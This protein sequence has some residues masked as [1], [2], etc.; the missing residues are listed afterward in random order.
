MSDI[1]I[2]EATA[3]DA[4]KLLEYIEKIASDTEFLT[5][6]PGEF[7]LT[8]DQERDT[9]DSYSLRDNALYLVAEI[10]GTIVG[11]LNFSGGS[12]LRTAHTGEFG[13]SVLKAYWG[14]HIGKVLLKTLIEWAHQFHIIRKIN[15]RVREDNDRAIRLYTSLG[16][17]Q[18]GIIKRDLFI[19]GRFYSS[20]LMGLAI[21]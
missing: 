21:N 9:L 16:F 5:F 3:E 20:V 11:S 18:E 2:R 13:I 12:R 4:D 1:V 8:R 19:D 6:G 17:I 7:Q 10:D 14:K 15:L